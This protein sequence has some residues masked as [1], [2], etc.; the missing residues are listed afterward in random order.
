MLR[1]LS[2]A[3]TYALLAGFQNFG[4][5]AASQIGIF[6]TEVREREFFIDNLLVRIHIF[7]VMIL[8]ARPCAIGVWIPFS[9]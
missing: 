7:I 3:T 9:R 1:P 8:V 5:V 4:E 6:A 2:Q